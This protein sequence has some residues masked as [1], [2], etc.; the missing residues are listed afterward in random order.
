[1]R[2]FTPLSDDDY[3]SNVVSIDAPVGHDLRISVADI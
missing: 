2:V 1:M 3:R